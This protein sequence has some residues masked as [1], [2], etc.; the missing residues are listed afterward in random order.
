MNLIAIEELAQ[1]QGVVA[2]TEFSRKGLLENFAGPFSEDEFDLMARMCASITIFIEMQGR[3]LADFT[4]DADWD[5]CQGWVLWG[6]DISLITM[7]DTVSVVHSQEVSFNTLID[8]LG[9]IGDRSYKQ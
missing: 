1:T 4:T 2:V 6:D 8:Q 5:R 9:V 7:R 3:M